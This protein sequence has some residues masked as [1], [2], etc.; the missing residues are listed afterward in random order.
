MA[1]SNITCMCI[2]VI[3]AAEEIL[4][5]PPGRTA[6]YCNQRVSLYVSPLTYLIIFIHHTMVANE[7]KRK[8]HVQMSQNI[9]CMLRVAMARYSTDENAIYF[10]FCGRRR[11]FIIFISGHK[12]V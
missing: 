7:K 6:K 2:A 12:Y 1:G 10:R 11:Y 9:P 4:F 3:T 5:P 8:L